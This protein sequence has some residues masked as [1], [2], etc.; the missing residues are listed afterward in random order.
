MR[1]TRA[2]LA[3]KGGAPERKRRERDGTDERKRRYARC[4]STSQSGPPVRSGPS[5]R[6]PPTSARRGWVSFPLGDAA[7][8]ETSSRV[9][10][11]LPSSSAYNRRRHPRGT[12][13]SSASFLY[14]SPR[15]FL[16]R[17]ISPMKLTHATPLPLSPHGLPGLRVPI[18]Y[19]VDAVVGQNYGE[20]DGRRR[21]LSQVGTARDR[22][23]PEIKKVG[24]RSVGKRNGGERTGLWIKNNV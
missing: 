13:P 23:P 24:V 11:A 2:C 3:P 18:G 17:S 1:S 15:L 12:E 19:V 4:R 6:H 16:P 10:V 7:G 14:P 8:P 20:R 5:A 21:T 22:V 9:I